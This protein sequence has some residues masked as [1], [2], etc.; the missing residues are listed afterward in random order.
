MGAGSSTQAASSVASAGLLVSP[1]STP[2]G[3]VGTTRS[4]GDCPVIHSQTSAPLPGHGDG[5]ERAMEEARQKM[6][7]GGCPMVKEGGGEV[8]YRSECPAATAEINEKI[9]RG[10]L[11]P[12]NL[13]RYRETLCNLKCLMLCGQQCSIR[14]MLLKS[15]Y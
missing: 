9:A 15:C 12:R 13:V 10:E 2:G 1:G 4:K 8:V 3:D 11:D 6:M 14:S 7:A 5:A